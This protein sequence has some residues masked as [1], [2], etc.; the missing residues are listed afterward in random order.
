MTPSPTNLIG[1]KGIGE[2]DTIA[3]TPAVP[4]A[5]A[6]TPAVPNVIADALLPLEINDMEMPATPDRDL[7]ADLRFAV[8][9]TV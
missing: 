4:N 7:A 9:G 8:T 5:I 3:S 1:V 2:A 6:S